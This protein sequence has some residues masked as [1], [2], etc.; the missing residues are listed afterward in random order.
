M[1]RL[2]YAM[3]LVHAGRPED[4]RGLLARAP[5]QSRQT[6]ATASCRFLLHALDG[7]KEDALACLTEDLKGAA[8]R[9]EWWSFTT[10]WCHAFVGETD[11]ALDWLEN[12]MQRGF[13]HYP[14]LSRPDVVYARLRGNPR[15]DAL[16]ERVKI[17]WARFPE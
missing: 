11:G 5:E 3:W 16:L 15:F 9:V 12:A 1:L 2:G 14:F 4:A 13:I 8:K 6:V 10:S 7:R 17:A